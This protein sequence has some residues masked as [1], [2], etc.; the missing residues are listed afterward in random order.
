[1]RKEYKKSLKKLFNQN[2]TS[3]KK[4]MSH[5]LIAYKC[6]I[7]IDKNKKRDVE[8]V[9]FRE[10]KYT[11]KYS[12]IKKCVIGKIFIKKSSLAWKTKK[13]NRNESK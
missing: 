10:V 9:Q 11:Q 3:L 4:W 6:F 8:T 7:D 2:E 1:M 12:D 5:R 13:Y